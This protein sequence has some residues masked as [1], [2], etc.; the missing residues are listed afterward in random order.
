M[1]KL[2]NIAFIIS[3]EVQISYHRTIPESRKRKGK[4]MLA[5][6]CGNFLANFFRVKN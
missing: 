1:I 3:D 5:G 6:I 4:I 2:R